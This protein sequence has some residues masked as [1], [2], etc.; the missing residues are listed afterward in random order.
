MLSAA[1]IMLTPATVSEKAS[2]VRCSFLEMKLQLSVQ[3]H[4]LLASVGLPGL[5]YCEFWA[6][7]NQIAALALFQPQLD[8]SL[9]GVGLWEQSGAY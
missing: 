7:R 4:S 5:K 8:S 9:P 6:K 1:S 3:Q 2:E